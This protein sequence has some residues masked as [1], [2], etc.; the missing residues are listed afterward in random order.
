MCCSTWLLATPVFDAT[1]FMAETK[2]DTR[3]TSVCSI[4]LMFSC[5]PLKTSCSRM[6]ASR[7]R[8]NS[9]VVSERSMPWVSS[10]S[11]TA[12]DAV[13]LDCSTAACVVSCSS[14]SVRAIAFEAPCV[15]SSALSRRSLTARW[16]ASFDTEIAELWLFCSSLSDRVMAPVPLSVASLISRAMCSLLSI[17]VCVKVKPLASIAFTAWSVM[18]PTSLEN[19]W[20][21]VLSAASSTL[22]FSS[23]MRFISAERWLTAVAISSALPTKWRATSVLTPSS[24]RSTSPAFCLS[25]LLTPVDTPVRLRSA[26]CALAR[27]DAVVLVASCASARS[28]SPALVLIAWLSCSRRVVSMVDVVA[29][30]LP[31]ERSASLEFDLMVCAICSMRLLIVST[32]V[33][34]QLLDRVRRVAAVRADGL[35]QL[36]HARGQQFGGGLAADL[37][38]L[39]HRLGAAEQQ[40]FEPADAGIEVGGDFHGAGAHRAVDVVDL[41]AE[42]LGELGAAHV[43]DA[44][45]VRNALVERSHHLGAAV[46]QRRGHLHDAGAERLVERRG[47]ALERVLEAHELLVEAGGDL[48]RL[49]GDAGVE[50]VQVVA[51]R[52]GDFLAALAQPLDHLAAVGLHRAVEF[53]EVAGDEVSK[54]GGVARDAF[55]EFGAAVVEHVLERLQARRQHFAHRVAAVAEH[56]G[57]RLGAFPERV[58]DPV[59]ALDDGLGDARAGLFELGDDVAAAQAEIEHQRVAGGLEGRIHLVDPA[60]DGLGQPVAGVDHHVGEFLRPVGHHVEDGAR[61][62]REAFGHA[63]EPH[64]HHVLQVGGDLGELVADVVGLEVQRRGQAVA[65]GADRLAGFG[66]GQFEAIEQVAAAVAER[67]DHGVAGIAE[68]AGDVLALFGQRVGDPARGLVDLLGDQFADLRNVAAEIEVDAVD[69]IADLVGLTDQGF[70]LLAE[71]LQQAAD[72]HLVVVIGVLQ[73]R[74]LVGDQRLEFGGARQR[75]LDA[76]AHGGDLAADRLADGDDGFARDRLGLGEAHRNLGH[77]L[78]DQPQLLRAP[79]HVGEHEEEDDRGE[80][81]HRQHAQNRRTETARAERSLQFGQVHPAEQ[82]AGQRPDHREHRRDQIRGAGRAAL[83]RAEDLADRLPVVVGG[84]A[85]GGGFFEAGDGV[86]EDPRLRLRM[87]RRLG[88]NRFGGKMIRRGLGRRCRFGRVGGRI[89]V[90]HVERVLDRRQRRFRRILHFLRS[91]RHVGRRLVLRKTPARR[92]T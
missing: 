12:A 41:G 56:V 86:V 92:T 28:A 42:V 26:S 25:T 88:G 80:E 78:G 11:E 18:R 85:N 73:R 30:R 62:L 31:I 21:L 55:G 70:A 61:L 27:I 7:S 33:D 65:G 74:H 59:G 57:Q 16:T 71:V 64:R 58:R 84:P 54:R 34:G 19:S 35:R 24:V 49:G 83:D 22:D 5:A 82:E 53:A 77:R 68:R 10:I 39:G 1:S 66:A 20:L 67:L 46:G 90:P 44:G 40:F 51:H 45:D 47:A 87:P 43:D 79:R 48:G 36:F 14:R 75:A 81:D 23:R 37:D 17:I 91:V 13:C 29:V 8:S 38:F 6:L 3:V 72:A 50:I 2:S 15:A 63:I 60:R 89:G 9:A 69:G 52:A 32:E 4:S 76:V